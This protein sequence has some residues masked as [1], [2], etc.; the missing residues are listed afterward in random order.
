MLDGV[1][2][3]FWGIDI[4][5]INCFW[6]IRVALRRAGLVRLVQANLLIWADSA[7]WIGWEVLTV[8][9]EWKMALVTVLVEVERLKMA[10]VCRSAGT[11]V[12]F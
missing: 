6:K 1:L 9:D 12:H 8:H 2:F 3:L 7:G 4:Q 10:V 11:V 5:L